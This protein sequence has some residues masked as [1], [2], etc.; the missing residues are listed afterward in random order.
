[1]K[2]ILQMLPVLFLAGC[3]SVVQTASTSTANPTNGVTTTTQARSS[4]YAIGNARTIADKVRASAGKTASVGASGVN[5]DA[6][7]NI[8]QNL[9]ALT[10]LL[11]SLKGQ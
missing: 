9:D 11:N 1:M 7:N 10:R 4:I 2:K 6:T 3:A 5:E 8:A